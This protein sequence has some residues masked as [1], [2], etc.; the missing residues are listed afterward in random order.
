VL[1]AGYGGLERARDAGQ[2]G[3]VKNRVDAF[4]G[5]GTDLRVS[6]VTAQELDV[7]FNMVDVVARAGRQVVYYPDFVA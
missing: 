2:C 6:K 7:R 5:L 4:G 1:V 3:Y